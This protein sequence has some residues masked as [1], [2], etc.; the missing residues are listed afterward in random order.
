MKSAIEAVNEA[1]HKATEELY[2]AAMAEGEA[3]QQAGANG[4]GP[5]TESQ[6]QKEGPVDAD[7]E[8]VDD[9]KK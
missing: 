4:D 8:V 1:V 9:D 3:A 2:K 7:Y 5:R 6:G